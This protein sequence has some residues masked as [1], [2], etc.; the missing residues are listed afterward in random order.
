MGLQKHIDGLHEFCK[1]RHM[2]VNLMITNVCVFNKKASKYTR[3][4]Q[5][6]YNGQEVEY[7]SQYK[8]LGIFFSHTKTIFKSA[9]DYFAGQANKAIFAANKY[10]MESVGKLSPKLQ[11]KVFDT[12]ILLILEYGSEIWS[13]CEEIT[14]LERIQ[15]KYLKNTLCVKPQTST[16]AVYGKLDDF[17]LWFDSGLTS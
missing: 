16:L 2:I 3:N 13:T 5:L 8:Y 14:V 4:P 10:A 7:C 11:L 1:Q 12:Q 9:R 6:F 17:H 15:L